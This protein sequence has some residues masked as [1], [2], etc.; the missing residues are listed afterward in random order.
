MAPGVSRIL[1]TMPP[2]RFFTVSVDAEHDEALRRFGETNN[3]R[4]SSQCV[5]HLLDRR[6]SNH[7][8]WKLLLLTLAEHR[9]C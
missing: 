6:L 8:V 2:K 5:I 9:T 1:H 7:P 4:L 3:P